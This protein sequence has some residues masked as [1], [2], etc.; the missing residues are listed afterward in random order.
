MIIT[1]MIIIMEI[2]I[3]IDS[4]PFTPMYFGKHLLDCNMYHHTV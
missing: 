1:S 2:M 4:T 3:I